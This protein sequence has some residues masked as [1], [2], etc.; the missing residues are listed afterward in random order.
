MRCRRRIKRSRK[1]RSSWAQQ[2]AVVLLRLALPVVMVASQ[3]RQLLR[4]DDHS[5]LSRSRSRTKKKSRTSR[6]T[7][8]RLP[9]MELTRL[10]SR[11]LVTCRLVVTSRLV[12]ASR[13]VVTSRLVAAMMLVPL[14]V[15]RLEGVAP[16]RL[17]L[18]S[19]RQTQQ[20][21]LRLPPL[22]VVRNQKPPLL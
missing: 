7:K 2:L 3:H 18:Q 12:V 13:L 1:L 22:L 17:P 21:L 19:P 10:P 16:R 14:I 11:L 15:P 9:P 5:L 8:A 4:E 6:K 20:L